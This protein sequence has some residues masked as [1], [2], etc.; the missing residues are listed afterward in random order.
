MRKFY[1]FDARS[2]IQRI[3]SAVRSMLLEGTLDHHLAD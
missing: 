2:M 1:A 3:T